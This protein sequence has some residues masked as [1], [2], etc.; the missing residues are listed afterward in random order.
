MSNAGL[1]E[2]W[3]TAIKPFGATDSYQLGAEWLK[4]CAT[5]QDWGAGAGY[6]ST[7]IE[8]GRYVGIDG[9]E[10][11]RTTI[12]A[13]LAEYRSETPGLF[14]RHVLEHCGD[15][16]AKVLDN[17]L[18]SFTER[19]FL[20]LFIPLTDGETFDTEWEDPPGVPNL[21][22]NRD[23]LTACLDRAN[24]T[25]EA[26]ELGNAMPYGLQEPKLVGSE[27]VFRLSK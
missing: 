24:V 26:E 14:I 22:I 1:W 5:V 4:D 17:A 8:P 6:M 12:I 27:T 25:W 3:H 23:E 16:W 15:D 7:L 11:P 19:M 18:A 20:I 21:S 10:G 13:D 2:G 9:S